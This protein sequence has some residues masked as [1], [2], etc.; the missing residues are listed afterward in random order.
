MKNIYILAATIIGFSQQQKTTDSCFQC[1]KSNYYICEGKFTNPWDVQ[2][3]NPSFTDA[4]C[5]KS[6]S[7]KCSKMF[8]E[9]KSEFYSKCP[10][11]AKST[12]GLAH[13]YDDMV[14]Y[15]HDKKETF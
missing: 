12:C 8:Y 4:K 15:A 6:G 13:N 1:A 11:I 2:C 14:I 5:G 3:C 10:L 7:G 9:D